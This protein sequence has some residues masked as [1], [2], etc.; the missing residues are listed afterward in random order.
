MLERLAKRVWR[1]SRVGPHLV[2][3]AVILSVGI[4]SVAAVQVTE[5][6]SRRSQT[7]VLGP[8]AIGGVVTVA[9]LLFGLI[10]TVEGVATLD[11]EVII[12]LAEDR[13]PVAASIFAIFTTFGDSI[14]MMTIGAGIAVV[15]YRR[16]GAW[17]S[18][19]VPAVIM[20]EQILQ[21]ST[22]SSIP[23]W[24]MGELAPQAIDGTTGSYP[25][26][27]VARMLSLFCVAALVCDF[28]GIRGGWTLRSVAAVLLVE[29]AISRLYLG[30]HL[31]ADL[32]GGFLLGIILVAGMA[33]IMRLTM[34]KKTASVQQ[35][36]PTTASVRN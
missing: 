23:A 8:L 11:S 35:S 20:C 31:L 27:S 21:V 34:K 36:S 32:V 12:T 30:R 3:F 4:V 26:G 14:P 18:F 13:K 6:I 10:W 19:L 25:S 22:F 29:Q 1:E 33:V 7:S 16:T 2:W 28:T 5:L 9:F 17:Q 15:L 24:T